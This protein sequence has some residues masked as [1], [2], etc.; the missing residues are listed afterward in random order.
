M[1]RIIFRIISAVVLTIAV[2]S[3]LIF[4]LQFLR[5]FLYKTDIWRPLIT[6]SFVGFGLIGSYAL[7][8]YRKWAIVIYG[9]NFIN[10]LWTQLLKLTYYGTCCSTTPDRAAIAIL[11]SGSFL[12]LVY[13]FRRRLNGNYLK[14][15]PI[16]LFIGFVILN[17]ISLRHLLG[18]W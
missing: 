12:L 3:L 8:N 9:I 4:S 10:V 2:V 1:L 14:W 5:Y 7:W 11:L 17:Q 18:A 13:F 16:L 15:L 6:F